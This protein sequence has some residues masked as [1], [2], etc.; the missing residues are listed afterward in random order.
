[1]F[2]HDDADR[3]LPPTERR[4]REARSRGEVARSAE[5]TSAVTLLGA[6]T[7]FWWLA[8][9][10]A[11]EIV[12]LIRDALTTTPTLSL[13]GSE[14]AILTRQMG[15]VFATILLP[16]GL[17]VFTG[18]FIA[19]LTQIG[20][21]WTPSALAPRF[22]PKRLFSWERCSESAGLMLR[23]GLL[24]GLTWWFVCSRLR[25][26]FSLG[27]GEPAAMF[28]SMARLL[29]ELCVQLSICLVL[30]AI[31][32]YGFRYWRHEQRLKMTLEERRREQ[33][34][35]DVDPRIKQRRAAIG[36]HSGFAIP[37]LEP[38]GSISE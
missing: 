31:I 7:V 14:I 36:R 22:R 18:G 33:K 12:G 37:P 6:S 23:L 16:A 1:M 4:R 26:L 9:S 34:E 2:S 30:L 19:N 3:T 10:W 38:V 5:L 35:D 15:Q 29:G 11:A 20:W 21:I 17:V 27:S 8:P 24:F 32:D 28:V 25:Q 13:T